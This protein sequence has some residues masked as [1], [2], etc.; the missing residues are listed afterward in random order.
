MPGG[1]LAAAVLSPLLTM[2]MLATSSAMAERGESSS[3]AGSL[4]AIA[5]L[6]LCLTLPA[7]VLVWHVQPGV[8][9]LLKLQPPESTASSQ[10]IVDERYTTVEKPLLGVLGAK[11]EPMPYP[12]GAWRIDTVLVLV[13]GFALIPIALGRWPLG[14]TEAG[15]LIIAYAIYLALTMRM[16]LLP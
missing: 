13:L 6:N 10:P 2:P 4:V 7:V 14:R 1:L 16:A 5:L 9:E 11:A 15:G 12:M 3:M 8:A